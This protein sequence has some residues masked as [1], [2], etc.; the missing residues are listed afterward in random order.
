MSNTLHYTL[1]RLLVPCLHR[2]RILDIE[3]LLHLHRIFWVQIRLVTKNILD[4]GTK[5]HHRLKRKRNSSSCVTVKKSNLNHD[6]QRTQSLHVEYSVEIDNQIAQHNPLNR[7]RT[8]KKQK[9]NVKSIVSQHTKT[10]VPSL[11]GNNLQSM[12]DH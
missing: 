2:R 10:Y 11:Y 9:N 7:E 3:V 12:G 8:Y 6:Q 5:F 1:L 4:I